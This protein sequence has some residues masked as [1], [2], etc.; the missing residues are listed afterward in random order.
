MKY[1]LSSIIALF[2]FVSQTCKSDAELPDNECYRDMLERFDMDP[3][4][5]G[6][7]GCKL[8]LNVYQLNGVL[9]FGLNSPCVDIIVNPISCDGKYYADNITTE[10]QNKFFNEAKFVEVIGVER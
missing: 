6:D 7:A 2:L 3:F 1:I 5:G 4:P 8:T 10:Q 9:Y